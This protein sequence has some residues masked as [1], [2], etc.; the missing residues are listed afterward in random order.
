MIWGQPTN[1]WFRYPVQ[2]GNGSC[3]GDDLEKVLFICFYRMKTSLGIWVWFLS[4]NCIQILLSRVLINLIYGFLK[5]WGRVSTV[6]DVPLFVH[7]T[8]IKYYIQRWNVFIATVWATIH[9]INTN[10]QT[11]IMEESKNVKYLASFVLPVSLTGMAIKEFG[12]IFHH[13]SDERKH[14]VSSETIIVEFR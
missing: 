9:S 3:W 12:S 10:V 6:A 14:T 8:L 7:R 13:R 1:P 5:F 4:A 11:Q 2:W